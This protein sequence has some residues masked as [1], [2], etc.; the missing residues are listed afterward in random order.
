LLPDPYSWTLHLEASLPV[1]ALALGYLA[2][3]RSHSAERLRIAAF[4]GGCAL[5]LATAV[6]PLDAL[7]YH[8]LSAHLLQNV[9]LA[10]WA[11]ALLVLGLPPLLAARI[12]AVGLIRLLTRPPVALT[13]WLTTY[14]LWHLPALYDSALEHSGLLHLEHVCYVAAGTLLWWPV[15]QDAPHRLSSAARALYVFVA[16]VLASPIGLLL[17]LLPEPVYDWY[18]EGGGLWGLSPHADQQLAGVAMSVE[19]AVVFFAV[20]AVFFF[21]FLAEEEAGE[22][23]A[24]KMGRSAY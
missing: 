15:L 3:L 24:G 23:P 20:F 6:S 22:R 2:A 7:T 13:L 16:F 21:R 14:F 19:Q 17:A 10:E 9:V 4:A 5:L 12:A 1:I 18:V 8:L 11:P